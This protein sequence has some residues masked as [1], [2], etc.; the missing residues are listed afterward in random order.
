MTVDIFKALYTK[1]LNLYSR[2]LQMKFIKSIKRLD[3]TFL[4]GSFLFFLVTLINFTLTT[5]PY[6]ALHSGNVG[7]LGTDSKFY[8]NTAYSLIGSFGMICVIKRIFNIDLITKILCTLIMISMCVNFNFNDLYSYI[9][10]MLAIT[11]VS[12]MAL[13]DN[14]K[15]AYSE[16]NNN[17]SLAL[18]QKALTGLIVIGLALVLL[19]PSK[20]GYLSASMSRQERG[21][22]T[23]WVVLC[24]PVLSLSLNLVQFLRRE[25]SPIHMSMSVFACFV[26]CLTASRTA[27]LVYGVIVV[28]FYLLK[29]RNKVLIL[30]TIPIIL[31]LLITSESIRQIFLLGNSTITSDN[32]SDI[33]NGRYELWVFYLD[34]FWDNIFFG[35][36]PNA[37]TDNIAT[38][39]EATSEVGILKTAASYGIGP[40]LIEVYLIVLSFKALRKIYI[41]PNLFTKYDIFVAFLFLSSIILIIQQHARIQNYG[42]LICWYSMFYMYNLN[43]KNVWSQ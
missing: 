16:T 35:A 27:L 3:S 11:T 20:Y 39:L 21:E 32:V 28:L 23:L 43:K 42:N 8:I 19:Y 17:V 18:Y 26:T 36:G 41:A 10:D 7:Y 30:L 5:S 4:S 37:L 24:L 40:V 6:S 22:V 29:K 12:T 2:I 14:R 25:L 1:M 13:Y 38:F 9:Y 33:L 34:T 15:S 31:T